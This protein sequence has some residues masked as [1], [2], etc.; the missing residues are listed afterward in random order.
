MED[1]TMIETTTTNRNP[2]QTMRSLARNCTLP[3]TRLVALAL[4]TGAMTLATQGPGV[5][6]ETPEP[7]TIAD[8]AFEPP[9]GLE[10]FTVMT[11]VL[12]FPPG[13]HVPMHSHPSRG[14]VIMLEGEVS[15]RH[16]DGREFV[17]GVGDSWVEEID[18]V[19]E[20]WNEGDVTARLVWTF[21]QPEGAEVMVLHEAE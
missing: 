18:D 12:D 3:A 8:G 10:A 7:I 14:E 19:H 13:T 16:L 15:V 1:S 21:L 2:L 5:T 6:Q 11:I 4:I 20:A 17:Y 9:E